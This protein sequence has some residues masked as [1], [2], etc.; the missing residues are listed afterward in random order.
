MQVAA[1]F[2]SGDAS[3]RL[4]DCEKVLEI[5]DYFLVNALELKLR[6]R[7]RAFANLSGM[8]AIRR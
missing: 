2:R 5:R 6:P 8:S 3:C 4:P 7:S 1:L